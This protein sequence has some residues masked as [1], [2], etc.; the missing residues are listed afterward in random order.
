MKNNQLS[1]W[2]VLYLICLLGLAGNSH[3]ACTTQTITVGQ[4]VSGTLDSADCIATASGYQFY[5]DVYSFSATAG[6]QI[7]ILNTSTAMDV[8]ITL[9]GPDLA[10]SYNDDGGGGTNSRLPADSG[11]LTI[12][13]SGTYT[14]YASTATPLTT[15]SYTLQLATAAPVAGTTQDAVEYYNSSFGHYFITAFPE[16]AS[17]LDNKPEWN[18][19][20]TGKTFKV[21]ESNASGLNAVCRF[22]STSFA[23]KSSHFY[24]PFTDECNAI[25]QN[26]DW[27]FEANAFYVQTSDSTGVCPSGTNKVYRLYNN[28]LSGAPNHRYTTDTSVRSQMIS[29]GWVS[30]GYGS[31]GVIFCAPASSGGTTATLNTS[32]T[33]YNTAVDGVAKANLAFLQANLQWEGANLSNLTASEVS[34]LVSNFLNTG[35]QMVTSLEALNTTASNISSSAAPNSSTGSKRA[36]YTEK[37][38][39]LIDASDAAGIVDI[40]GVSPGL[41]IET[42]QVIQG[43]KDGASSCNALFDSDPNAYKTCIDN[44]RK[45]QLLKAAGLGFSTVVGTGAAVIAGGAASA[46]AAPAAVV[47]GGAALAGYA[48]G[49]TVSWIWSYCSGASANNFKNR[50]LAVAGETCS[51]SSGQASAGTEIPNTMSGGGTLVISIPGYVPMVIKN[52]TPPADGNSLTIDYT[53]IPVDQA[54]PDTTITIDYNEVPAIASTC[55]EIQS[56]S[57]ST[58]PSDPGPGQSVTVIARVFPTISG[59][60]VSFSMSGTDGYSKSDNPTTDSAGTATFYIPGASAGVHDAVTINVNGF[61]YSV[62]YTF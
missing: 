58:N 41:V 38:H 57:V 45:Q 13:V 49:K 6:E 17:A 56:A 24:T 33:D 14:I 3:A 40:S 4:T 27:Q 20:R 36:T 51:L 8:D 48:V 59:C 21:Y 62:T 19:T 11:Y 43:A 25:K 30:E 50:P 29:Q 55:S 31:F 7:Y 39:P 53:P 61:T 1:M 16:E 26:A 60:S 44:L 12:A 18:W 10:T 22:F 34:T 23:P 37:A 9:I 52:F 15:G 47:I 5:A 46:A 28:G 2:S 54:E 35:T 42:A 32:L